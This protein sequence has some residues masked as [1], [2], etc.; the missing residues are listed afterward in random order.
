MRL[1]RLLFVVYVFFSS[2]LVAE[3][4]LVT[5]AEGIDI[6][7][8][9]YPSDGD[10]LIIWL[11]DHEED[12]RM[13]EEMLHA[14]NTAGAEIWRVD[15]LDAYFLPRTSENERTLSGAGVAALISAAHDKRDKSLLLV[16][17]DRMPLTLLRGA[18]MWQQQGR[19][20][21]LAGAVLFYPNLFGSAPIAGE[22]PVISPIVKQPTFPWLFIS[23]KWAVSAGAWIQ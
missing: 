5:D 12:R 10:L 23:P 8:Q 16:A 3:E 15:L 9:V 17:Y 22:D 1:N 14:V 13:F 21:R 18:R 19:A 7:V 2:N 11:V 20:S 4:M 6:S